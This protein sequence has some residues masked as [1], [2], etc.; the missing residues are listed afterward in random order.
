MPT[1]LA[2]LTSEHRSLKAK[3][4]KAVVQGLLKQGK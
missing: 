4:S 1:T 2:D 3:A